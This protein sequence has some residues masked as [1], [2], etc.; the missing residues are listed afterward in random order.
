M[1]LY[2]VVHMQIQII[3]N[4]PANI[5]EFAHRLYTMI[6]ILYSQ[7]CTKYSY[8]EKYKLFRFQHLTIN[9]GNKKIQIKYKIFYKFLC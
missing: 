3:K 7:W 4:S 9:C 5:C 1:F 8:V 2:G 6:W